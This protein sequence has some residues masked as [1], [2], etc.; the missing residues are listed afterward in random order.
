MLPIRH[1]ALTSVAATLL[2]AACATTSEPATPPV[3]VAPAFQA[4]LLEDVRILSSDEMAGRDTGSP[5]GEMARNY[6]VGRL[7]A[8]GVAPPDMPLFPP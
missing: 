6:I 2:L 3:A 5:G 4:Q 7:G 1:L 8:P